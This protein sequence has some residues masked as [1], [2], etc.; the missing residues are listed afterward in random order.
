MSW[1]RKK[2]DDEAGDDILDLKDVV[3]RGVSQN[4]RL[5]RLAEAA[6]QTDGELP[7]PG[8]K[9]YPPKQILPTVPLP[10]SAG[11]STTNHDQHPKQDFK[12]DEILDD[13]DLPLPQ[14][15]LSASE[16]IIETEIR[17]QIITEAMDAVLHFQKGQG[18]SPQENDFDSDELE[19]TIGEIADQTLAAAQNQSS[20]QSTPQNPTN[21]APINQT[22]PKPQ[23]PDMSNAIRDVVADEIGHW[24][25]D[26]MPRIIAETM[27]QASVTAEQ[28]KPSIPPKPA[29]TAV[30]TTAKNAAKKASQTKAKPKV[31]AK[32]AKKSAKTSKPKAKKGKS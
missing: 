4:D 6:K 31:K 8:E 17:N 25:K 13:D 23:S 30:K 24:L 9:I 2:A 22:I 15:D 1:W 21:Q 18:Q 26:H 12:T 32:A 11:Q 16:Q 20:P 10:V 28:T 3:W 27:A 29:Q 14:D 5:D 7:E 19:A